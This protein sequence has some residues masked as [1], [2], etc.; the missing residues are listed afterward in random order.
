MSAR[1][2]LSEPAGVI[3][4]TPTGGRQH[5][6]HTTGGGLSEWRGQDSGLADLQE[7]ID[8]ASCSEE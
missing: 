2:H 6:C 1:L 5:G 3:A 4:A 8:T 7:K